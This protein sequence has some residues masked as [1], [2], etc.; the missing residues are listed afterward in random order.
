[1]EIGIDQEFLQ[2]NHSYSKRH[3]LRGLHYQYPKGQ[4]KLI[5]VCRGR[6]FDVAV[7]IRRGSPTFGRWV[8]VELSSDNAR[9]LFIPAGF[10]HG[11]CVLSQEAYIIYKCTDLY[12]PEHEHGILWSD[13]S[14]G[15]KWPVDNPVIS[16]RDMDHPLL[17]MIPASELPSYLPGKSNR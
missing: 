16:P 13:P 2:D 4:A 12:A 14:I 9:Q 10:A 11:F 1:V 7:D 5:Y 15:I 17:A 6:I 8:G 3:V